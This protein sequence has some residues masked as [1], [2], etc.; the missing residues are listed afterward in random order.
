[1]R[2]NE[3]RKHRRI[4]LKL[5]VVYQNVGSVSS[6]VMRAKTVNISTGGLLM[7]SQGHDFEQGGLVDVSLQVPP[8][9][10]ML[11]FG[12]KIRG[13]AKVVR[14]SSQSGFEQSQGKS[15]K[16]SSVALEFCNRPKLDL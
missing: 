6:R 14:F 11:E 8:T 4:P 9:E 16:S 10:G 1:M 15:A 2:V 12:G 13:Y 3:Q 7:E 5:D